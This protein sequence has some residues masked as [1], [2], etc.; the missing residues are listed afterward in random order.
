M[1]TVVE[2]GLSGLFPGSPLAL[3]PAWG[4]SA[5]SKTHGSSVFTPC[6]PR[7][8]TV[9]VLIPSA[10]VARRV[11]P[12]C[13]ATRG[14]EE[15]ALVCTPVSLLSTPHVPA[16]FG[17]DQASGVQLDEGPLSL[18]LP[19]VRDVPA[20]RPSTV[21]GYDRC[22]FRTRSRLKSCGSSGSCAVV[23]L[24][25]AWSPGFGVFP[26]EALVG[27]PRWCTFREIG[28][29]SPPVAIF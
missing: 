8:T 16:L 5:V 14:R 11:F 28:G 2:T 21:G 26:E 10:R 4:P 12:R 27:P 20:C 6:Q 18:P 7:P 24:P 13:Y 19:F 25:V 22:L 1:R 9:A 23:V 29:F 3:A 15:S 17:A